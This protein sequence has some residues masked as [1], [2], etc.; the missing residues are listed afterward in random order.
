MLFVSTS[1][2]KSSFRAAADD[3]AH[4]LVLWKIDDLF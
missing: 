4:P 3:V 1:G 2:F